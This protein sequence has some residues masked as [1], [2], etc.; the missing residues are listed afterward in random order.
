MTRMQVE[1]SPIRA[2]QRRHAPDPAGAA[3]A[4]GGARGNARL[5]SLVGGVLLVGLAIEGATIPWIQRFLSV[6]IF[7]GMLLLGPVVLKL[8]STGYRVVRYYAGSRE[9]TRIGPPAPLMRFLV[10][11][12]LVLS[13][14]TLFASGVALLVEPQ[15]GTLL[16]LHKASFIVWF[17]AMTIHVLTYL[18]RASRNLLADFATRH[19]A[20]RIYRV[21]LVAFA[22]AAGLLIATATY[23]LADPWFHQLVR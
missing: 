14:V 16:L 15:R 11:P 17:G 1:E 3:R 2:S 12:V 10:A 6:H 7:V 8:G 5:T 20:G 19:S 21:A 22:L 13:T 23:S 4:L 18:A 9:Y